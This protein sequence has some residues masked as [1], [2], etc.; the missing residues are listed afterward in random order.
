MKYLLFLCLAFLTLPAF[1]QEKPVSGVVADKTTQERIAKVNV[2]NTR[3]GKSAYNNLKAEFSINARPGDVL[4]FSRQGYF[5][6]T[7]KITGTGDIAVYLKPTAIML[8]EVKVRDSLLSPMRRLAMAKAENSKAY[9]SLAYRDILSVSPIGAGIS[10]DAIWNMLSRSGRNAAR[11]REVIQQDYDQDVIDYRFNKAFVTSVTG[12]QEPD[13]TKF[14]QRYRPSYYTVSTASDYD[15][16]AYIK[17]NLKRYQRNP[18]RMYLQPLI[19][20]TAAAK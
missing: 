2:R 19:P 17:G 16:I 4:I 10:I 18:N 14:M 11:L 3:S 1:C 12:L 20:V 9:G 6:D 15:F 7:V 13:L 5:P 8:K